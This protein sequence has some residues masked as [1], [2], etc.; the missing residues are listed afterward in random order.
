MRPIR[1]LAAP[2]A[3][4]ASALAQ[5]PAVA[6]HAVLNRQTAD[7]NRGDIEAFATG[8]KNAS[9]I[10]FMGRTIQHGYA[11]MLARYKKSLPHTRQNGRSQLRQA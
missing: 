11:E 4:A 3:L 9:D 7:W 10:L 1:I 5:A 2:V 8:Y 6:I